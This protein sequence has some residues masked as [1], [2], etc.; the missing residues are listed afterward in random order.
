L[1]LEGVLPAA[2][3]G[4]AAVYPKTVQARHAER[5]LGVGVIVEVQGGVLQHAIPPGPASGRG[6]FPRVFLLLA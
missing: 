5:L 3:A 2:G 1:Q 4:R 6:R